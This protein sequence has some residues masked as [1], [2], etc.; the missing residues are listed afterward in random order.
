MFDWAKLDSWRLAFARRKPEPMEPERRAFAAPVASFTAQVTEDGML[1][2]FRT[3]AGIDVDLALNAYAARHLALCITDMGG[4]AGW[5]DGFGRIILPSD[6]EAR[7]VREILKEIRAK[8][9]VLRATQGRLPQG[10][11]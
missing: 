5:L 1:V 11:P 10:S 6:E 4:E 2:R 3:E 7:K 9:P 8:S